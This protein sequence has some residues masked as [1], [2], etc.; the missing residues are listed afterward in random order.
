MT[1]PIHFVNSDFVLSNS[2]RKIKIGP[3]QTVMPSMT[4]DIRIKPAPM[5]HMIAVTN[6]TVMPRTRLA[7]CG[8]LITPAC[9]KAV[10]A[11]VRPLSIA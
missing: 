11:T 10:F 1:D 3:K 4:F 9:S 2:N 6:R 7:R 5:P 8:P